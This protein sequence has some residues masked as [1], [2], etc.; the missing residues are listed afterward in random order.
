MIT[1]QLHQ[2]K[3]NTGLFSSDQSGSL[4]LHST[5]TCLFK[6]TDDLSSG[7]DLGKLMGLVFVDLKKALTQL[8]TAFSAKSYN[9]IVFVSMRFTGLN[10]TCPIGDSFVG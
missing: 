4:R 9:I 2:F 8:T 6:S 1:D 3:D 5:L 10:P 7:L